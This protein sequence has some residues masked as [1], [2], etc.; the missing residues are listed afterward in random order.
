MHKII[1]L[2]CENRRPLA[3]FRGLCFCL[4]VT[5]QLQGHFGQLNHM[6]W[7]FFTTCVYIEDIIN[8]EISGTQKWF[9]SLCSLQN[10]KELNT[11]L[12]CRPA[13]TECLVWKEWTSVGE[14]NIEHIQ[15]DSPL[16]GKEPLP[17]SWDQLRRRF[18]TSNRG[19]SPLSDESCNMCVQ[20]CSAASLISSCYQR[21]GNYLLG[22]T[23]KTFHLTT[24]SRPA[25]L[26]GPA[27]H[28]P[29]HRPHFLLVCAFACRAVNIK[30]D[31]KTTSGRWKLFIKP[32][33][34]KSAS[35]LA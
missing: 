14:E 19:R 5:F 10:Q 22:F 26:W 2:Y 23:L 28:R 24:D 30:G 3:H 4:E 27:P 11:L 9:P 7:L 31:S 15:C 33:N 17:A 25:A 18:V 35:F 29:L 16:P 21:A 1:K 13:V 34:S 6:Y 32:S 8:K 12:Q 20:V